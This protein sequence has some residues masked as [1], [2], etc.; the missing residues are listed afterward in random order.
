MAFNPA[1]LTEMHALA[2]AQPTA[3]LVDREHVTDS[4]ARP[5]D[6]VRWARDARASFLGIHFSLCTEAVVTAAHA[7][8]IALGVFTVNDET[9]IRRLAGWGVDVVISDRADLVARLSAES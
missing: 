8:G 5:E 9:T 1:V 4:G 3:L 7:A 6:T 2:P